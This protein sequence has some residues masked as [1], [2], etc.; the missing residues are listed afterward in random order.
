MIDA[1]VSA[2]NGCKFAPANISSSTGLFDWGLSA[3]ESITVEFYHH[4]VDGE[5]QDGLFVG[6]EN[7]ISWAIKNYPADSHSR[8]PYWLV[9]WLGEDQELKEGEFKTFLE[10]G[11]L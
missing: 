7:V 4:V 6:A 8:V 3:N 5:Q 10:V 11:Y 9:R 1:C 2:D